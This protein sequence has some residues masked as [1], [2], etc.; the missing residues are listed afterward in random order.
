MSD[1]L[2][3][4]DDRNSLFRGGARQVARVSDGIRFVPWQAKI[5]REFFQAQFG[6]H[7]FAFVLI[8][9]ETNRVH[10][11]GKTVRRLL[12]DRGAP[13]SVATT[14][15]GIYQVIGDQFG[16][17]VHGQTPADIDGTFPINE[18]ARPHI[19]IIQRKCS[20]GSCEE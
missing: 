3:I 5:T 18:N 14:I 16:R 9:P 7:L 13:R 20:L 4:Y 12:Q 19:K 17:I 1:L 10:A 15:E 11:G 8:N 2:L 6:D